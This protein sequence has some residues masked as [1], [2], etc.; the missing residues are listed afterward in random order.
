ML[1]RCPRAKH[2]L[3]VIKMDGILTPGTTRSALSQFHILESATCFTTL[4]GL[5]SGS[6]RNRFSSTYE[7]KSYYKWLNKIPL[8]FSLTQLGV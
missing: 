2:D 6:F 5:N 8:L 4:L 3:G 1:F 7:I